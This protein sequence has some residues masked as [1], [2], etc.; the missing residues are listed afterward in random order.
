M[1]R[2]PPRSTRTDT[3]FP[4]TTLFRSV[5]GG[6]PLPV[7]IPER[8]AAGGVHPGPTR[9]SEIRGRHASLR[10]SRSRPLSRTLRDDDPIM[11]SSF[12]RGRASARLRNPPARSEAR[13]VGKAVRVDLGGRRTIKKK[14][15]KNK[16]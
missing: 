7:V 1:L 14:K 12:R 13:R 9:C 5:S 8:V 11:P 15:Q 16:H 3:L 2:R 4:Y 10:G 6:G